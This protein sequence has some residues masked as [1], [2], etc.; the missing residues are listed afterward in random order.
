MITN[1]MIF[2]NLSDVEARRGP[3]GGK[4]LEARCS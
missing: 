2:F 1:L 4:V 3:C